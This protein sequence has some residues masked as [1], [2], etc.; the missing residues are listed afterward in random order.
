M[1]H[2]FHL[3]FKIINRKIEEAGIIPVIGYILGVVGLILVTELLF[4]KTEF[5]KYI[6][7]LGV[8]GLMSKFQT[9]DRE[10]FL[11]ATYGD[12]E[13]RKIRMVEN[14][15][16]SV[17]FMIVLLFKGCFLEAFILL[18]LSCVLAVATYKTN[19]N[20]VIPTPFTKHPYEF[21]VGFRNTFF[22]FPI[23]YTLTIIGVNVGNFNLVIF[24]MLLVF[25]IS[26]GYHSAPEKEYYVWIFKDS[27]PT[28]LFKKL[29]AACRNIFIL[30][31]PILLMLLYF[32]S[33]EYRTI[34]LLY[35]IGMLFLWTIILAKYSVYPNEM[36]I[37][38]GILI[39][40]SVVFPP[41]LLFLIPYYFKK[42]VNNLKIRL[43]DRY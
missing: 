25:L 41:L 9:K 43:H 29:W 28:F 13:K 15:L 32:Y 21:T 16:I 24:A 6:V 37:P 8:V 18:V 2:Y 7:V 4:Y 30:N 23:A 31:F 1:K 5:A 26:L 40:L 12:V 38:E 17:P 19:V 39:S 11:L 33:E 42:S 3:Q 10:D 22:V 27:P 20:F 14:L 35:L 34:I 36:N